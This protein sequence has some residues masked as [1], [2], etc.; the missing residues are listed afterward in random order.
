MLVVMGLLFVFYLIPFFVAF[1]VF[2]PA[3]VCLF[4]EGAIDFPLSTNN[5]LV[6]LRDEFKLSYLSRLFWFLVGLAG[7]CWLLAISLIGHRLTIHCLTLLLITWDLQFDFTLFFIELLAIVLII[8][9]LNYKK[10]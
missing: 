3:L 9:F 2:P 7:C 10:Y 4:A 6:I 1:F 5:G 8:Y